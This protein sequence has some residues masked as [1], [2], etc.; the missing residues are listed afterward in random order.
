MF[1]KGQV[2]WNKGLKGVQRFKFLDL[3]GQRF[4]RLVAIERNGHDKSGNIRWKCECDCGNFTF[5]STK[6][7]RSRNTKSCGCL[8][9]EV[10]SKIKSLPK[11]NASFNIFFRN[12]IRSAKKRNIIFS[13]SEEEF[14][15]ITQGDC[16]YCGVHPKQQGLTTTAMNG[17][18]LH[19]GIDRIDNK[20]GYVMGNCIA[21]CKI[22]N[23]AKDV[24]TQVEFGNWINR[25]QKN[26][27]K[28]KA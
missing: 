7:L 19:N 25:V 1:R 5:V 12:Y 2:A 18:Y 3:V 8:Q 13:L 9:K 10:T 14:R 4:N 21:C 6:H 28:H 22:C 24:M 15:I 27:N 20:K 26:W 16:S 11:G 23:R 17:Y